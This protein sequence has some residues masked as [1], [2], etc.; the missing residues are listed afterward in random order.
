MK[1][2]TLSLLILTMTLSSA[3]AF[4][5]VPLGDAVNA[6]VDLVFASPFT[7][8]HSLVAADNLQAGNQVSRYT[9][10]AT[11]RVSISGTEASSAL[12]EWV[13]GTAVDSFGYHRTFLGASSGGSLTLALYAGPGTSSSTEG[14]GRRL[15]PYNGAATAT[16]F[17]YAIHS[18]GP[19]N[20]VDVKADTYNIVLKAQVYTA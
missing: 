10:V 12:V 9:A 11:G 7:V 18:D 19:V 4:A 14:N 2:H 13:N 20:N 3:T 8:T 5:E 17:S 6:S 1:K 15:K 16:S